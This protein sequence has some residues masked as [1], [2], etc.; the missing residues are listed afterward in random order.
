[1]SVKEIRQ[2]GPYCYTYSPHHPPIATVEPGE[3][4]CIHTLD[5][6]E[7]RSA[8]DVRWESRDMVQSTYFDRRVRGLSHCFGG[9]RHDGRE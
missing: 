8:R 9:S 5:A 1:M 4:V 7:N 2:T 6:F 3:K